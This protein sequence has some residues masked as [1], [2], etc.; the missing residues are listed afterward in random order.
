MSYLDTIKTAQEVVDQAGGEKVR[1]FYDDLREAAVTA[2]VTRSEYIDY[3]EALTNYE[4][5]SD[6]EPLT[7]RR[8]RE[9]A[10]AFADQDFRR[11]GKGSAVITSPADSNV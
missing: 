3:D 2:G 11:E 5:R 10:E 8:A 7:E 6:T 1:D 9:N 4:S